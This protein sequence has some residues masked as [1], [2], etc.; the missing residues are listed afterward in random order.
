MSRDPLADFAG[1]TAPGEQPVDPTLYPGSKQKR[2]AVTN[3]APRGI[4]AD[5]IDLKVRGK[6]VRFYTIGTLAAALER[7]PPTIRKWERLGYIPLA[8]WHTPGR[9]L[10]GQKRLYT[11]PEIEGMVRIADEEGLLGA[12][13]RNVSATNFPARVRKLFKELNP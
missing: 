12:F 9:T 1:I 2:K 8:E 4:W 10:H 13:N 11:R 5:Y 7:K 3:P 6:T